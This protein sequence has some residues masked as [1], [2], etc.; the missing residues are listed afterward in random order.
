M[1]SNIQWSVWVAE[2]REWS[3]AE[4]EA[5]A[6]RDWQR[7]SACQRAKANMQ[8]QA[9]ALPGDESQSLPPDIAR[10]VEDLIALER[11]NALELQRLRVVLE[12]ERRDLLGVERNLRRVGASYGAMNANSWQ[13][14]S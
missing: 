5:I 10:D 4:R 11:R 13:A 9:S 1:I 14:Y 8:R 3:D 6:A 2:W 7:V 12:T